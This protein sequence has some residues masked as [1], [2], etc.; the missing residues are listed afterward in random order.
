MPLLIETLTTVPGKKLAAVKERANQHH[1][2][3]QSQPEKIHEVGALPLSVQ[4]TDTS[5]L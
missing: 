5:S 1:P 3:R 4:L 2:K